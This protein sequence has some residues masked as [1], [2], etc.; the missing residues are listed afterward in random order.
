MKKMLMIVIVVISVIDEK[1]EVFIMKELS[2]D[3]W[4][5]TLNELSSQRVQLKLQLAVVEAG[6]VH[7]GKMARKS[8]PSPVVG[9]EHGVVTTGSG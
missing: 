2:R 7:C 9:G 6:I 5:L 3:D 4:K 1:Q 8:P